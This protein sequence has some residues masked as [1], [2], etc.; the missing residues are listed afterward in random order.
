[1]ATAQRATDLW[2]DHPGIRFDQRPDGAL[3]RGGQDAI[4]VRRAGRCLKIPEFTE[5]LGTV[6]ANRPSRA[7]CRSGMVRGERRQFPHRTGSRGALW[8]NG[9]FYDN[10]FVRQRGA[11]LR[12]L[13]EV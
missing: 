7:R 8:F 5:Y 10:L 12:P 6:I 9:E 1:M 4:G 11:R 2:R 13:S 3:L